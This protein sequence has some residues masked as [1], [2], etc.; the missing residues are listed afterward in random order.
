M[1]YLLLLL[2]LLHLLLVVLVLAVVVMLLLLFIPELTMLIYGM[3]MWRS[4][5]ALNNIVKCRGF[6][7]PDGVRGKGV[8]RFAMPCRQAVGVSSF[9]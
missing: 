9:V 1:L 3:T 4:K 5:Q 6:C 2:S 7:S 8:L